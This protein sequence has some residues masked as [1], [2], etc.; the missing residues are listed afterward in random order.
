[1]NTLLN[2]DELFM[3][4]ALKEAEKCLPINEVPVGAVIVCKGVIIARGHNRMITSNNPTA[5][6]EIEA[7]RLAGEILNNYRLVDT[8]LY[9]TLEPCMMCSGAMIHARVGRVVYGASDYKT[10]SVASAFK[11]L[12]DPRH[13]HQLEVTGGVLARECSL[14]LSE[15]FKKRRLEHKQIRIN[16]AKL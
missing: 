3:N 5:H 6:A 13:N 10:G 2:I 9:V 12:N 1:M 15:F 8:T 11:L 16:K 4:E 14:Q 7:I